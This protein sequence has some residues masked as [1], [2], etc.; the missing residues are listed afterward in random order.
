MKTALTEQDRVWVRSYAKQALSDLSV[1][2]ILV[3]SKAHRCHGLHFLQMAV[4]KACKAH[5]TAANGHD[6][7]RKSHAYIAKVLPNL[8][9]AFYSPEGGGGQIAQWELAKIA[10]LTLEIEVLAPA[11]DDGGSRLDNTEYPWRDAQ[12]KISVPCEHDFPRIDDSEKNL[13]RLIKL[14]R[15]ALKTYST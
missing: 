12:G 6:N 11:C 5:L 7:V 8:A 14:M 15:M 1:R 4:E 2:E 3:H 13:V 9:R 10:K